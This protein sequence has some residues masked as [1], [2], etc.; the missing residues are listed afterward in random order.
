MAAGTAVFQSLL[1]GDHVV[2]SRVMYYSFRTW[3]VDFGMSWG[4]DV[5]FVDTTNP[6]ELANAMRPGKTKLVFID[7]PANPTQ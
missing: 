3:L 7:T 1:P 6:S 2:A 5:E 4:L